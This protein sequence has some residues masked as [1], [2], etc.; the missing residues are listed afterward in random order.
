M[1]IENFQK[2]TLFKHTI[3]GMLVAVRALYGVLF[4][5]YYLLRGFGSTRSTLFSV[6][7]S[8]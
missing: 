6:P 7:P 2:S 4:A 3:R 8:P 1:C 5:Q